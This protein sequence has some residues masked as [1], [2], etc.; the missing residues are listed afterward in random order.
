[1]GNTRK[2]K[3][4]VQ[5][6][7][8]WSIYSSGQ[9]CVRWGASF[10]EFFECSLGVKQGCLF[11]PLIFSLFISEVAD[12]VR[13]N[14]KYGIQLLPGFEQPAEQLSSETVFRQSG[15]MTRYQP[16]SDFYQIQS[17][18][19]ANRICFAATGWRILLSRS[20]RCLSLCK[21]WN[22]LSYLYFLGRFHLN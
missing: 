18:A 22:V 21:C 6:G 7:K 10:S 19:G 16:L 5:N 3:N 17:V 8:F 11:S 20:Q 9:A 4:L 12:F 1:M 13:E 2:A 14:G 15:T